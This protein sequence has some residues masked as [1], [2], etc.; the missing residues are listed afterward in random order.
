M[1]QIQDLDPQEIL[2]GVLQNPGEAGIHQAEPAFAHQADAGGRVVHQGLFPHLVQLPVAVAQGAAHLGDEIGDQE[3][4]EDKGVPHALD[5]EI[6]AAGAVMGCRKVVVKLHQEG[7]GGG[8][9][10]ADRPDE[11][12]L[13]G[14]RRHHDR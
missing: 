8:G 9:Q 10:G 5:M 3:G 11:A 1:H 4:A 7:V 6:E 2:P 12:W 13:E 14:R